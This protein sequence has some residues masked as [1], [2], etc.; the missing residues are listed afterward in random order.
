[1]FLIVGGRDLYTIHRSQSIFESLN[2][3]GSIC[4]EFAGNCMMTKYDERN[5]LDTSTME[6]QSASLI[7]RRERLSV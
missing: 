7:S 2:S 1:M 4:N 6:N 3:A 5:N